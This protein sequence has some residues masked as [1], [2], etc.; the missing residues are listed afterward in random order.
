MEP[1]LNLSAE[2][3]SQGEGADELDSNDSESDDLGWQGQRTWEP[4]V[5]AHA[6]PVTSLAVSPDSQWVASGSHDGMII[7]WEIESQSVV[8]KWAAHDRTVR[9]LAFSPDSLRLAS[10]GSEGRVMVWDVDTGKLLAKMEVEGPTPRAVPMVIW[11][12]DGTKLA[13][14]SND[15]TVRIWDAQTY[16]PLY[17]LQHPGSHNASV[18][19]SHSG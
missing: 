4:A 10:C 9:H 8:R 5:V 2:V 16:T 18:I 6:S 3:P 1:P 14:S 12:P 13:S 19:F 15:G 11:S 17:V 7:L